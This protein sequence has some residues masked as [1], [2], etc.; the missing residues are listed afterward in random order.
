MKEVE[1]YCPLYQVDIS[2]LI[3]GTVEELIA[4]V[5]S[6]H[7]GALPMSWDKSFEWGEDAN[8]TDGYQFH[9][10]APFGVGEKFYVWVSEPSPYL[11]FHETYH[12]T[13]DILFTRGV[14]YCNQCEESFAYLG[15]WIYQELSDQLN[16]K[17]KET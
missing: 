9:I 17:E 7:Q 11:L 2:Y 14:T 8:T 3:G 13:G 5:K 15:G 12:L 1:I 16:N 6:R 10:N 4:L